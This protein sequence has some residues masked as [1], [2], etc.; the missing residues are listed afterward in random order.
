L[1]SS[2]YDNAIA[3]PKR[4]PYLTREIIAKMNLNSERDSLQF[5]ECFAVLPEALGG[6]EQS[7][8]QLALRWILIVSLSR[9]APADEA[10]RIAC[11]D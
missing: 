4:L 5:G 6:D 11:I 2:R 1:P 9:S 8:E 10:R 3:G 7:I